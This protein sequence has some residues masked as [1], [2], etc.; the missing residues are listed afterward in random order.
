MMIIDQECALDN[1]IIFKIFHCWLAGKQMEL[2]SDRTVCVFS[3]ASASN[4]EASNWTFC[5][6]FSTH[7]EL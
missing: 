2:F 6:I 3:A 4:L 1:A 5:P 7:M